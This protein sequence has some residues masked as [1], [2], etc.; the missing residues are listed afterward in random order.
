M[1]N[2]LNKKRIQ[3]I[4]ILGGGTAGWMTANKLIASWP[5][6]KV[7]L[8]ESEDIG[9]IGVG[10]GSTPY[11]KAFFTEIGLNEQE[12]M[13][14]CSATYKVGIEF[15]NWSQGLEKN[16]YFHPFFSNLDKP[17]AE[18]FFYNS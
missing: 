4:V 10:E 15:K 16:S 18:L 13:P 11:L 9:I 7:T 12:W 5:H 14:A 1:S 3:S 2:T 8:I 6:C 17:S